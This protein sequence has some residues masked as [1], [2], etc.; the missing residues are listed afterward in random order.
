MK[1]RKLIPFIVVILLIMALSPLLK[2]QRTPVAENNSGD[3]VA[4]DFTL[5][6]LDNKPFRFFD[7]K[8]KVIILDFWATWC[9]PC[10]A[11]LPHFKALYSEYQEQGLEIVG[12][13]LDQGGADVV[14]PFVKEHEINYTMLISNQEVVEDYG[15][16]RGIPTTFIIDR[17]GRIVETF[18]GYRDKEVFESVIQELL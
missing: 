12:V 9:P 2:S 10:I 15:G 6:D 11:E 8:G 18:V 3:Q 14:R 16:I 7:L 1:K 13:S 17:E 5:N 4:S